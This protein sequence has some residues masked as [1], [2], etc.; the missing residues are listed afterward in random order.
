MFPLLLQKVHYMGLDA[1]TSTEYESI[2]R[3]CSQGPCIERTDNCSGDNLIKH[4]CM[5][6]T[7]CHSNLCNDGNTR[8]T[9]ISWIYAYLL[10]SCLHIMRQIYW[11]K[12][13]RILFT[14]L[15]KQILWLM[16]LDHNHHDKLENVS[17]K[18]YELFVFKTCPFSFIIHKM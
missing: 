17:E 9:N 11:Q 5:Q 14:L 18:K 2:S 8:L 10:S 12:K 16:M 15:M 1:N 6:R 7:C 4:G 3:S 13:Q